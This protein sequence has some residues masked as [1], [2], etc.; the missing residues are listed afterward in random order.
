MLYSKTLSRMP[1]INTLTILHS[2]M[3]LPPHLLPQNEEVEST[4][5]IMARKSEYM[6]NKEDLQISLNKIHYLSGLM[7]SDK[8]QIFSKPKHYK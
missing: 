7:R 3:F 1:T 5:L 2:I 4:H 6:I 8:M